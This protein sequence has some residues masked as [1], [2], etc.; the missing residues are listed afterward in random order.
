MD[1]IRELHNCRERHRGCAVTLGNF[2]GVH[3]GHQYLL[4]RLEGPAF[5]LGLRKTLIT[6]EPQPLEHF[7]PQAAPARLTRFREKICLLASTGLDQVLC[8]AFN[9]RLASLSAE[10]IVKRVL[11]DALATRYLVVGD[12]FRFG[13][14]RLG[15]FHLLAESGKKY[16]FDVERMEAV[17]VGGDRISST[18]VRSALAAGKFAEAESLLGHPYSIRGRV[19][20]GRKLARAFGVKTANIPLNRRVSPVRGVFLAAVAGI[21]GGPHLGLANLGFRPTLKDKELLL[22]VHLLDEA[23]DLYGVELRVRFLKKIR[24]EQNFR[25]LEALSAQIGR[26]LEAARADFQDEGLAALARQPF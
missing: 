2:D 17:K 10:T 26:D 23:Q 25:D 3:R 7:T 4:E 20:H 21:K 13:R 1:I 24:D 16:G 6:F 22:E 9:S 15:D 12:D 19:V 11:V 18:R 14:N 8:M 5:E